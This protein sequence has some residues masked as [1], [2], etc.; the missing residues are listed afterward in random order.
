M[1]GA[2]DTHICH[3]CRQPRYPCAHPTVIRTSVH[4]YACLSLPYARPL[5]SLLLSLHHTYAHACSKMPI[6]PSA[7]PWHLPEEKE[8]SAADTTADAP[9][10]CRYF[11]GE[12]VEHAFAPVSASQ[13]KC[14]AYQSG[15]TL[16]RQ[17]D[18]KSGCSNRQMLLLYDPRVGT[19][20]GS[21][22]NS[23]HVVLAQNRARSLAL[24]PPPTH[25]THITPYTHTHTHT[26]LL[27][28]ENR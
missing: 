23:I 18:K 1:Q 21:C 28:W 15:G 9:E 5:L 24:A 6:A 2:G 4:V 19:A 26:Q 13:A 7:Q 16:A 17:A 20:R 22:S 8:G 10:N 11:P 14:G 3:T 25:H 12:Q 27:S